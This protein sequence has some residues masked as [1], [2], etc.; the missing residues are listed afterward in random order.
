MSWVDFL[1]RSSEFEIL[2]ADDYQDTDC[3]LCLHRL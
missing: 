2:E 3:L 1:A